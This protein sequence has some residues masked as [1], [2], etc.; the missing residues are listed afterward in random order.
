MAAA[1]ATTARRRVRE[2]SP[3][4]PDSRAPAMA[5][6]LAS[7]SDVTPRRWWTVS[8]ASCRGPAASDPD[9]TGGGGEVRRAVGI[10]REFSGAVAGA[11]LG[12]LVPA[13]KLP[14]AVA[15]GVLLA[16][17]TGATKMLTGWWA[18]GRLSPVGPGMTVGRA[19]RLRAGLTL[20]PRGELAIAIGIL[21]ALAGPQRGPGTGLAAL[22][23]VVVVLTGAPS[24][25]VRG[26]RRPGWYRWAV[27]TPA[28]ARPEP[29]GAG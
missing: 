4:A 16:A 1:T 7:V 3:T 29:P 14:G 6:A 24:S 22:A 18:A 21:A 9:A 19:G 20:V 12:F 10:L 28:A 5:P 23:A 26:P 8:S 13:S 27:P 2:A 25:A 17:L 11:T 15:G